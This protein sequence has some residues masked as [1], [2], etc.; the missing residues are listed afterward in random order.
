MVVGGGG[1]GGGMPLVLS[2]NSVFQ[3]NVKKVSIM[4]DAKGGRFGAYLIRVL[5]SSPEVTTCAFHRRFS[6]FFWLETQLKR[7]GL[8]SFNRMPKK[9]LFRWY[10]HEYLEERRVKLDQ[11]C[12]QLPGL[13]EK[14][15]TLREMIYIFLDSSLDAGLSDMLSL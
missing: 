1:G 10:G 12:Q 8:N 11:W 6:D 9:N 5:Q 14:Y 7:G 4:H 2:E 13:A 3:C 15:P